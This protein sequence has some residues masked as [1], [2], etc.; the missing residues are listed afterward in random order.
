MRVYHYFLEYTANKAEEKTVKGTIL[1]LA[2]LDA[3]TIAVLQSFAEQ[4]TRG[5]HPQILYADTLEANQKPA[6]AQIVEQICQIVE[7]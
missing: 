6:L 7:L 5:V 3:W 4:E 1:F 2:G